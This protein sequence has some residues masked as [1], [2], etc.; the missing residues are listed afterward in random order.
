MLQASISSWTSEVAAAF[1]WIAAAAVVLLQI[2]KPI[3]NPAHSAMPV[4]A[5]ALLALI[6]RYL[7]QNRLKRT[8]RPTTAFQYTRLCVDT[9]V[10]TS[11][12]LPMAGKALLR[13]FA[14]EVRQLRH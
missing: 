10:C 7:L 13:A 2:P 5:H 14:T 3:S 1:A 4:S 8:S 11:Q 12:I 6:T 9:I